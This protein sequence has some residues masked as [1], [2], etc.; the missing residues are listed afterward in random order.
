MKATIVK[1]AAFILVCLGF[2]AYLGFTIG[3]IRIGDLGPFDNSYELSA[4]F[5]DV[6]GLLKDDNVKVAGVRVGKV[7]GIEIDKG[8][9]VVRFKVREGLRLPTDTQAAVRWRN[10]LGQRYVYLYPGSG[11][12]LLDDGDRV[13]KTRS[14]VDLGEL[15]NR[16]GPIVQAIDPTQVNTFLDAVVG[17][18]DGNEAKVSRAIDDL[19]T[20]AQ[21]LAARDEAIGRMIEN[22]DTVTGALTSRDQQIK[23]VLDNLVKLAQTF[24]QNTDVLNRAVTDLGDFSDNLA[25]LLTRNRTQIESILTG[26][27]V[28]T[29]EVDNKLPTL[30]AILTNL[31]ETAKRLFNA[32]RYGEWLNQV[33]PC[34][35]FFYPTPVPAQT[36]TCDPHQE[37]HIPT[38]AST[39]GASA[40]SELLAV[41]R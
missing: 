41:P 17:A 4:T 15:F 11:A 23:V 3:N 29:D 2:T 7:T 13:D 24:S 22:L 20:V 16:L 25:F 27:R 33:I 21:S 28:L 12:T 6:T 19:A 40:I 39:S 14:V 38:P 8:K 26:L 36:G 1:L 31:D 37:S 30:D 18:L 10:L 5:D 35:Q 9:A 34:G 32:S